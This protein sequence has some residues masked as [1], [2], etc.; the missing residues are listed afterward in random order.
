MRFSQDRH[1]N[2]GHKSRRQQGRLVAPR[3]EV[4]E[5]RTL[6]SGGLDITLHADGKQTVDFLG[7]DQANGVV[8]QPDGKIVLVG[9]GFSDFAV[10][11]LQR[12]GDL[13]NTF[14]GD[15]LFKH[16]F[17]GIDIATSVALQTD[18]KIVVAGYTNPGGGA[19]NDFAVIRVNPEGTIDSTFSGDGMHTIDFGFDDR[20]KGVVIQPDGKIVLGGIADGGS[21]D[22]AVARLNP[23]G[24]PDNSFN[25]DGLFHFN[26]GGIDSANAIALQPDGKIV[27]AGS[28]SA[29]GVGA[30]DFAVARLYGYGQ[31]DSTFS[32]DGKATIDFNFDDR[33]TGVVLQPDGKIVLSGFADG[34]SA[35]FAAA[36]LNPNGIPDDSFSGDGE[37]RFSFGGI[38]RANA[39]ALRPGGKIVMSGITSI[40]TNPHNFA[41]AGINP[42]GTLDTAFSTDGMQ[43]VDFGGNDEARAI[44]LQ[45]DGKIVVAGYTSATG[46]G[47]NDFA[48]V[49]LFGPHAEFMAVGGAPGGVHLFRKNGDSLGSFFPYAA[50]GYTGGVAVVFGDVNGDGSDDI[51][52]AATTGNPNVK[53]Y[54]GA[55][56]EHAN[57]FVNPES[58]L[59]ASGFPYAINYNVGA[60]VAVG[61]VNGD[62]Y[63]DLI[64]GAVPGNPHVRVFDGKQIVTSGVIPTG[65][66]ASVLAEGF[67][68]GVNF[69][70]GANVASGDVDGDGFADIITGASAGNP[71]TKVY[72]GQRVLVTGIISTGI[73]STVLEEFF[74]YALAFNVGAFVAAGDYNGDGF[75]D[76]ITGASVGN[77]EVRVISGKHITHGPFHLDSSVLDSFYAFDQGQNI[78][79]SVAAATFTGDGRVDVLAGTRS[80][81]AKHRV[82]KNNLPG[83]A[84]VLPVFD[85]IESGLSGPLN[86]GT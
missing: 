9:V 74:P 10:T 13:D 21:A 18:G 11:R 61:D 27:L 49:R 67:A 81:T 33:A 65:S 16:F 73:D 64:T 63:E 52:T 12:D 45:A 80:G 56:L 55:S 6:L 17:G 28:S 68:Y 30:N 32:S 76:V 39:I 22:F 24:T 3:L 58:K 54:N 41:I 40:G 23:N 85:V 60:N 2:H 7:N 62:G 70:V 43:I 14:S 4:L 75:A 20:A 83:A 48:V 37:L 35:D 72:D 86:V 84:T 77:P 71:H 47:A 19:A 15:G 50:S 34:G 44:G 38:D 25:G 36:R 66:D 82:F 78:G 59:L 46:S 79:V 53:V 29:T 31:L 5:D 26:F 1:V 57:S 69:N 42:N 8:V 51:I